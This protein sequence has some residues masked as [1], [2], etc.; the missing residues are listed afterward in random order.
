MRKASHKT[1]YLNIPI[2]SVQNFAL[3]DIVS[4]AWEMCMTDGH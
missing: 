2:F 3:Q 4:Y 1:N